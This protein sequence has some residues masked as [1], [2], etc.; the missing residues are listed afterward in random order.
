MLPTCLRKF[1]QLHKS[2]GL[3]AVKTEG[4]AVLTPMCFNFIKFIAYAPGMLS[5][6]NHSAFK[7]VW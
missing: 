3:G 1:T 2:C 5:A 7:N 4:L 6:K